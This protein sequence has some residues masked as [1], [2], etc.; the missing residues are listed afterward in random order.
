MTSM[1]GPLSALSK[2][3]RQNP[4]GR[5]ISGDPGPGQPSR[6]G[7]SR[8]RIRGAVD[9]LGAQIR[10]A[11]RAIA[12]QE[13]GGSGTRL[14]AEGLA[15]WPFGSAVYR[16]RRRAAG[17]ARSLARAA[18]APLGDITSVAVND[19]SLRVMVTRG[20]RVL[21]W[22]AA[23]IPPGIVD[24]GSV[25]D[26]GRFARALRAVVTSLHEGSRMERHRA[27]V[28]VSGRNT[29]QG[30]FV[31]LDNGEEGM[32]T[33]VR[34]LAAERMSITTSEVQFD[35]DAQPLEPIEDADDQPP[36]RPVDDEEDDAGE[37][38]EVY[39]LGIFRNV[40]ESI[41]RPVKR[42]GMTTV[43]V[44]PK[45][46]AL[47]AAVAQESAMIVDIEPGT[48]SVV[49]VR[50]GLP[51]VVRDMRP[52]DDLSDDQW[53]RALMAHIERTVEFH[54]MLNPQATV[55]PETPVFVTGREAD[56]NRVTTVLQQR[57]YNLAP[58]P[59]ALNAPDGFPI[60]EMA[61]NAGMAV[62][63]GRKFWQ[64]TL[65]PAV[66]RP[67]LR[68]V[69]PAYEPR[70]L[71]IKPIAAGAAAAVLAVGIAAG[72][73]QVSDIRGRSDDALATL[74]VL[75]RR[76]DV[77]SNQ[78]RQQ[79][80]DQA[81]VA[82]VRRDAEAVLS[83]SEAIRDRDGGFSRTLDTIAGSVPP[84]VSLEQVDDDGLLVTVRATA[85]TYDLL[86]DF[87]RILEGVS[88]IVDVRVNSIGATGPSRAPASAGEEL[89]GL[90][91][92]LLSGDEEIPSPVP[93]SPVDPLADGPGAIPMLELELTR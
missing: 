75:E 74:S 24:D 45:A 13:A 77:H 28:I 89:Y 69:P 80:R 70:T 34:A 47:A 90:L 44:S 50:D 55:G 18:A 21:H 31:L 54:D 53:S 33:A 56:A 82:A 52:A 29:I 43:A 40:L 93:G 66:E 23:D 27:G 42:S 20:N 36:A 35:W 16:A 7:V 83:A 63:R 46:L 9:R 48:V 10:S 5:Q 73:G 86:L 88:G 22:S 6:A 87:T 57:R 79:V 92:G 91:P 2:S 49:M 1:T 58:L 39:A 38:F 68:F 61:A 32:E 76:L 72:Y 14:P 30:R 15:G 3:M 67:R 19:S 37:P 78:F 64:K 84:G 4:G 26:A 41:L 71:P 85:S 11:G 62:L 65:I 60:G 12:W 8:G 25:V 17:L 51:E 59:A 81:Q